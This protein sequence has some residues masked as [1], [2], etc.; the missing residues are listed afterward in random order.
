L[1][2]ESGTGLAPERKTVNCFVIMPFAREFDD[3]YATIQSAVE[4]ACRDSPVYCF[5][6]DQ[7]RPAGRIT[8]RL[9]QEIRSASLC[10]ADVTE[11]RPNIM[12]EVGYAMASNK[13]TILITQGTAELPFDI[14]DMETLRY[15]RNHLNGSLGQ[16]LKR[17]V[18]DT[19]SSLSSRAENRSAD[20]EARDGLVGELLA[21]IRELREIVSQAVKSWN[22]TSTQ[23]AAPGREQSNLQALEGAWISEADGSHMYASLID[24]ELV[25]PY[26]FHGDDHLTSAYYGWKRIGGFWFARYSWFTASVSG[27]AFLKQDSVDQLTGAWW[28]DA[29]SRQVPENPDMSSGVPSRWKRRKSSAVPKWAAQFF[30]EVRR[31]GIINRMTRRRV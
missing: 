29:G 16:P 30:E 4:D 5:R 23:H 1:R 26:C 20:T 27:F 15:D 19:M 18:I 3:V 7:S 10:I 2:W 6:L 22:P 24:G 13:P 21:Q 11:N 25:A 8:E 28:M 9:V 12:W 14:W 17:M 31:E